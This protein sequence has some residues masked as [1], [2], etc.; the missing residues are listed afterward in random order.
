MS[1]VSLVIAPTL[2]NI[3]KDKIETERKLKYENLSEKVNGEKVYHSNRSTDIA[4]VKVV[5]GTLNDE[6]DFVYDTGE[7]EEIKLINEKSIQLGNQS[8]IK[9]F[10]NGVKQQDEALLNKNNWFTIENLYFASSSADLKSGSEKQLQNLAE[11][12]LAFPTLNIKLGGYTDNTGSE[13]ANIKLSNMRAQTAKLK[14]IE[15]GISADRIEAEGYGS[16]FPV[17]AENDTDECKAKNR[18]IEVRVTQF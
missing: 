2:A 15:S 14:L 12:M 13:E 16:Q 17:C 9:S 8:Q 10:Y 3:Y 6:G 7:I 1:I 18:R 11:I 4:V 5:K